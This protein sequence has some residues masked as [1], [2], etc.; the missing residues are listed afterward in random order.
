MGLGFST[1]ETSS[2]ESLHNVHGGEFDFHLSDNDGGH[3]V[4]AA[5]SGVVRHE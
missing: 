4:H 1:F 2:Y 3:V 5:D